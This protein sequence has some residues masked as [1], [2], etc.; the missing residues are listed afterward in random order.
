MSFKVDI[1]FKWNCIDFI[2]SEIVLLRWL[3]Y[4]LSS[5]LKAWNTVTCYTSAAEGIDIALISVF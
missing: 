1:N 2:L 3:A 4:I 5:H